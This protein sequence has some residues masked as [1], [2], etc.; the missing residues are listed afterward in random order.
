MPSPSRYALQDQQF[1]DLLLRVCSHTQHPGIKFLALIRKRH[2][3]AIIWLCTSTSKK[4]EFMD[5]WGTGESLF[6]ALQ[7]LANL[8]GLLRQEGSL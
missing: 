6:E 1:K 8:L 7:D 3:G 5:L 4:P 2:Q